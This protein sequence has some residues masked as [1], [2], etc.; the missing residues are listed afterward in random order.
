LR[1]GDGL[2]GR[3][4]FRIDVA[5]RGVV[6][7]RLLGRRRLVDVGLRGIGLGDR[8]RL[9]LWGRLGFDLGRL[10]FRLRGL[11]LFRRLVLGL[12]LLLLGLRLLVLDL[13]RLRVCVAV[14]GLGDVL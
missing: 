14:V 7:R 5:G 3:R 13:L 11:G 10:L 8:R 6:N 2:L 9:G 4:R 1:G 12:R